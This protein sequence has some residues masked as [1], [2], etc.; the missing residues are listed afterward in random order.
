[1]NRRQTASEILV[2]TLVK[3]GSRAAGVVR[4]GEL[5]VIRVRERAIDGA[6]NIAA[7][8]ALAQAFGVPPSDVR[9]VRGTG[10]R[11]KRFAI[12]R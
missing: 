11:R 7:A 9:L 5:V 3:P 12:R 2:E 1:V 10:A 6:A 8:R 4:E